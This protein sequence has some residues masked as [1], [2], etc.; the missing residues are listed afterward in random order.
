MDGETRGVA[1]RLADG[2]EAQQRSI[3]ELGRKIN[4]QKALVGARVR[5]AE[6][7]GMAMVEMRLGATSNKLRC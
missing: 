3:D 4:G 6:G 7:N 1:R 5:V 2:L